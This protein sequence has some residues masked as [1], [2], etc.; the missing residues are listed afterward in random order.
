MSAALVAVRESELSGPAVRRLTR[1]AT[2]SRADTT[3]FERLSDLWG[4]VVSIAIGIGV[5]AGW[6]ASLRER[7]SLADSA[8]TTPALP[9]RLT[10]AI[11]AVVAA[12][13]VVLILGISVR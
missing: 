8:V 12:A 7:I 6:V 4:N 9:T 13:G 3:L 2:A 10:A 5:L 11:A 1:R